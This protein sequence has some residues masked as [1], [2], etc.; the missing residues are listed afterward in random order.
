VRPTN[1][2]GEPLP[3]NKHTLA[4]FHRNVSLE[5][6]LMGATA[7][8]PIYVPGEV[9]RAAA[10]RRYVLGT[11]GTFYRASVDQRPKQGRA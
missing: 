11:P 9:S 1:E 2:K 7:S 4:G 5:V 6:T 8:G 10:E 3:P